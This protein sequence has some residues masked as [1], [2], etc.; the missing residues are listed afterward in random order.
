[1]PAA[2]LTAVSLHKVSKLFG[3]FAAVRQVSA[4]FGAGR[5]Y[6]ILG[7]NGAGKSTLLRLIAGL[8]RPTSGE[9]SVLGFSDIRSQSR[10]VGYMA[11]A[12]LLYDELSGLE[13]LRYFAQLY[14]SMSPQKLKDLCA[15][16]GLD[17][18]L[19]RHVGDY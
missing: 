8:A 16:V 3:R 19:E 1:M 6:A 10:R 7:E 11:H 13:N 2:S 9:I 5:C 4:D 15:Q 17:P 18:S 12:S 14:G